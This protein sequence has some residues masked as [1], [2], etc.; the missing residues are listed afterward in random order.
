MN[1]NQINKYLEQIAKA[2]LLAQK[3][4]ATGKLIDTFTVKDRKAGDIIYI[5]GR[6]EN[7]GEWVDTGRAVGA[8][9]VPIQALIEWIRIKGIASGEQVK[10][11][12][13][14]IQEKI[15]KEGIPT[16]GSRRIAAKRTRFVKETLKQANNLPIM[17]EQY[18]KTML[19]AAIKNLIEDVKHTIK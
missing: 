8:R 19:E 16:R 7:Y 13:F 17:I 2:E 4:R 11:M 14:A 10:G 5:E 15:Y 6:M 1:L 9:R 12:A 3:H 18:D